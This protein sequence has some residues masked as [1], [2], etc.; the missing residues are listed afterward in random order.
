MEFSVKY[1]IF[2]TLSGVYLVVIIIFTYGYTYVTLS[3]S[4]VFL[5][6]RSVMNNIDTIYLWQLQKWS[7][8]AQAATAM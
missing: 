2:Y 1:K 3:S 6:P 8:P 5:H 7:A 4:L